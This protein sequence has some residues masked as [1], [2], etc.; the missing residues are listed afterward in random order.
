MKYPELIELV[1]ALMGEGATKKAAEELLDVLFGTIGA[2]IQDGQEVTIKNFGRF[3][4]AQRAA[5]TAH[6]PHTGEAI[7]VPAKQVIKF[8]PRGD[9][10]LS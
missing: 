10:K 3:Y 4:L 5:R 1:Q 9:L 7:A 6:N 8:T 2:S